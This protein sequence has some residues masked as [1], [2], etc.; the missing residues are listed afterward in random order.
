LVV[1]GKMLHVLTH[2]FYPLTSGGKS[3]WWPP[4]VRVTP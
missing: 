1:L 3:T 2:L 4:P